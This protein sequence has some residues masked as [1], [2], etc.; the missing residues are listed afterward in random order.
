MIRGAVT[1]AIA[2]A[3][4]GCATTPPPPPAPPI[5]GVEEASGVLRS[6]DRLL[7]VGDHEPGTYYSYPADD[8][9][10]DAPRRLPLD[11]ALLERHRLA[12]GP[13]ALDLEA[14][15]VLADGRTVILSE[16]LSALFDEEGFVTIYGRALAEFGGRGFEG[17]SVRPLPD[18]SSRVA[19]LWEGGYPEPAD[20]PPAVRTQMCEQALR[21]RVLI[22]DLPAGARNLRVRGDTVIGDVELKVPL[23]AGAE[24]Q[25]QRFR[26]PDLVWHRWTMDGEPRWGFIALISSG[27]AVLPTS[28]SEEE[29]PKAEDGAPLRWCYKWLQRFTIDGEPWGEPFDL[30]DVLPVETRSANWEGLGWW[31]PGRALVLI[32]DERIA[33]R[34]VNPQEAFLLPLPDGW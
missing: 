16:R 12:A 24:P 20:L 30:D 10:L 23:P 13:Y 26:A 33:R 4:S 9:P 28:D 22:H 32:Y 17:L 1:V 19:I 7:I 31:E 27:W 14:I 34:R 21:P 6:G 29:C 5:A 2:A 11:P 18:G 8:A 25:A 3:V 15:D